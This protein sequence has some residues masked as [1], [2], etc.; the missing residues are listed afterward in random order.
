MGETMKPADICMILE[1]TYPFVHGGVSAWVHELIKNMPDFTF[2]L[3]CIVPLNFDSEPCFEMPGNV[4][5]MKVVPLTSIRRRRLE[6]NWFGGKTEEFFRRI[7]SPLMKVV[8]QE[9][10]LDD[11]KA[12]VTVFGYYRDCL[13]EYDLMR[14]RPAWDL[15]LEIYNATMPE[16]SFIDF[17]WSWHTLVGG[18][19]SMMMVELPEARCYHSV[20]TGY[21]GIMLARAR[22]EKNASSILTEHGIYTSERRFEIAFAEWLVDQKAFSMSVNKSQNNYELRDLWTDF[23][24]EYGR[25]CY[26]SSDAIISLFHDNLKIQ[27]LGGASP[28]RCRVIPNGINLA[29][30]GAVVPVGSHSATVA[31]I[32]RIVPIKDV[33]T[34]IRAV[35]VL[36]RT[37]PDLTAYIIGGHDEDPEYYEECLELIENEY[38]GKIIKFTGKVDI[39]KYLPEVDVVVLSSISEAQPLVILEAGAAGIPSVATNVGSCREMLEGSEGDDFGPGGIVVPLAS[40]A[41]MAEALAR[42][43]MDD[44]FYEQCSNAIRKR[45]EKYY[46]SDDQFRSY[47]ELYREMISKKA[48]I[49]R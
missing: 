26:G 22:W 9:A 29:R 40:P 47:R 20:C 37:I 8:K 25:F 14:S 38:L 18:L 44:V 30:Y 31:F 11:F 15:L 19:F 12:L 45:V 36:S 7:R 24:V 5:G 6:S 49:Q 10:T 34:Y 42:L 39:V 17:F 32:G 43:L 46:S 28:E 21:A 35:G 48:I 3:V 16:I 1:G 33:K 13:N 23:F 2:N 41:A 4:V 27:V